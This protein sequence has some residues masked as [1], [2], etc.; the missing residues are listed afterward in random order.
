VI[1]LGLRV[2]PYDAPDQAAIER[3]RKNFGPRIV[4]AAGRHVYYKGFEYLIAAMQRV[5]AKALIAGDGPLRGKLQALAAQ[6]GVQNRV[7]FLGE[8]EDLIPYYHAADVFALPSIARSE[9]FGIVQLEAMACG[10]PVVNT[11]LDSEVPFVS[12]GGVTGLTVA[13]ENAEE[14]AGA[15]RLLM[16]SPALRTQ[17]GREGRVRVEAQ[18]SAEAMIRRTLEIYEQILPR[19]ASTEEV[20]PTVKARA[21]HA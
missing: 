8:V 7:V 9:A 12:I 15:I 20:I 14:L 6:L 13:P 11:L 16:D 1:P 4:L 21:A 18:F 2:E 10:R 19:G 5:D 17:Y 3:I